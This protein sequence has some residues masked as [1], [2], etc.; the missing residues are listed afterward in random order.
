MEIILMR[1]KGKS[2]KRDSSWTLEQWQELQQQPY[3]TLEDYKKRY[4]RNKVSIWRK[5]NSK[6]YLKELTDFFKV[7][8]IIY[9]NSL[10]LVDKNIKIIFNELKYAQDEKKFNYNIWKS[11]ADQGTRVLMINE[12]EWLFHKES[13]KRKILNLCGLSE[14]GVGA[15]KLNILKISNSE[16][17]K[18]CDIFHIQGKTGTIKHAYGAFDNLKLVGVLVFNQQRNTQ[19]IE[20]VRFCTNGKIYSGLFSKMFKKFI[21]ENPDIVEIISF[22]DLRY[23]DGNLYL[24]NG[25]ERVKIIS[26]DYRY[27][28]EGNTFHKAYLQKKE[29]AKKFNLDW[30]RE[31]EPFTETVLAKQLGYKRIYDVGK[32][33]YMWKRQ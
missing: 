13:I 31:V 28:K 4:N 10:F 14:K 32:I 17:N 9:E 21:T 30:V 19:A 18:F 12:D 11:Y 7:H 15:R 2:L 3:E 33:K 26:P 20:L 23:S 1:G 16:A 25:F 29:I 5:N 6:P 22:A 27:I 24:K 8:E